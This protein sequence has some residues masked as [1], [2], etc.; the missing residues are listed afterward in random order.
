MISL[1]LT[2]WSRCLALRAFCATTRPRTRWTSA[3]SPWEEDERTVTD[4]LIDQIES[5]DVIVTHH[6]FD[7]EKLWTLL[8]DEESWRGVLRSKGFFWLAADHRVAYE[9]AQAGGVCTTNPAGFWWAVV[10]R[11]D[12]DQPDGERPDQQPGCHPRFGDRSQQ[13][14]FIGQK[15]DEAAMRSRLD[16]CLLDEMLA[17]RPS[18]EWSRLPNPFPEFHPDSADS[19]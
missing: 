3:G 18:D 14:V 5:A 13:L 10:D 6:P 17:D 19:P 15:M 11:E 12:W 2:P 16:A 9:W 1:A 8:G 7:A 4:L